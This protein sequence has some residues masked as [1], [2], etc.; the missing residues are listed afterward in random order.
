M[1]T[2]R[3]YF[4]QVVFNSWRK[5]YQL[6]ETFVFSQKN[7]TEWKGKYEVYLQYFDYIEHK[8]ATK[9][10]DLCQVLFKLRDTET[11]RKDN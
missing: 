2:K 10:W 6:L 8:K 3:F 9:K 1:R 4:I 7:S 5:S 11:K